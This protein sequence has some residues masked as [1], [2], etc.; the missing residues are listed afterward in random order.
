MS[1]DWDRIRTELIAMAHEDQTLREELARDGSLFDGYHPRMRAVHERNAQ[2]LDR[3]LAESGWPGR[4]QVGEEASGA[5]WLIL[6]HAI[7][8]PP[9]QRRGLT[10][11]QK[12]AERGDVP[13]VEVAMLE[14][15][16][17]SMEGRGQRFG[18]QFDW[19]SEGNMSPVPIEDPDRV[20]ERR[21]S[22]GLGPL[23]E[24]IR[25]HREGMARSP[26]RPPADWAK[27]RREMEDWCRTVGWRG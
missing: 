4:S 17:R 12:A 5:A 18:T 20:D 15:R 14:D 7:G 3:I 21:R 11:L 2:R 8:N 22:V 9:L 16:I 1:T 13:A 23:E 26:E 6:Q 19:D 25:L 24:S 27:R 10:L